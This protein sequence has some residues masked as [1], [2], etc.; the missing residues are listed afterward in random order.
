MRW[1][2][3]RCLVMVVF[4]HSVMSDSLQPHGLQHA[5]LP[6]PSLSPRACSNS[7]PSSQW[8]HPTIS[9]SV[10]PFSCL[11]SFPASG[12]FPMSKFFPSG[13][14]SIGAS[15]SVVPMNIKGW[16][17]LGW[18]GL[19][20]LL[21]KGLSRVFSRTT[22]QTHQFCATQLGIVQGIYENKWILNRLIW[23]VGEEHTFP[24]RHTGQYL[25]I[26]GTIRGGERVVEDVQA[27]G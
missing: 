9:S 19:I 17:P 4:S 22:V 26:K 11:P 5:R 24:V 15:A 10:A 13:D 27:R 3:V 6:C 18:T 21:S 1:W 16:F 8:C 2:L 23:R 12:S 14:Q 20:S 25:T 7:C